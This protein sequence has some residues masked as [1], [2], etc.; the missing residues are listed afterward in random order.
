MPQNACTTLKGRRPIDGS[1]I[2]PFVHFG[3]RKSSGF[4]EGEWISVGNI[5]TSESLGREAVIKSFEF[6]A[7]DGVT[8][9]IE[10]LDERG[11]AFDASVRAMTSSLENLGTAV[12]WWGWIVTDCVTG[13]TRMEKAGPIYLNLID[14]N[15]T[16]SGGKVK[17]KINCKDAGGIAKDITGE[18]SIWGDEKNPM[19]I[20]DGLKRMME[21][22]DPKINI[23]WINKDGKEGAV[24]FKGD[25]KGVWESNGQD[26]LT[27]VSE[28][29]ESFVTTN[30]RGTYPVWDYTKEE[31]TLLL[32]ESGNPACYSTNSQRKP[33]AGIYVVNGGKDSN[34]ISFN[35]SLNW[36][37]FWSKATTRGGSS[38]A[39]ATGKMVSK[40]EEGVKCE[41]KW[42]SE[43][44]GKQQSVTVNRN[45]QWNDG[46]EGKDKVNKNQ[47]TNNQANSVIVSAGPVNAEL[48]MQGQ[49]DDQ[50]WHPT[51]C[52]GRDA[53]IVL[54][55][56]FHLRA[57]DGCE[58]LAEPVCNEIF[59]SK[60]WLIQGVAHSI[61]EGSFVTTLKVMLPP[62][63]GGSGKGGKTLE[64]WS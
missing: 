62:P 50:F 58:W 45:S 15:V 8:A 46:K 20:K 37:S 36:K 22:T 13:A 60:E 49:V 10:I 54:I 28:W 29:L 12:F 3:L 30:D 17:Y 31:P 64:A 18:D 4:R 35:P 59:T 34:V 48:K 40:N 44:L 61:R 52:I 47:V 2:S 9:T 56:P 25:P 7:S 57:K 26:K 63:Y 39:P 33:F 21:S 24:D 11:G 53:H 6:G 1:N 16:F 14:M 27:I 43:N 55:N 42:Q 38:G 51:Q 41:A 19:G 32:I 5:S 23:K